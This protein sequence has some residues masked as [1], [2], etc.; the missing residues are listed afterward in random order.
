MATVTSEIQIV[1]NPT[2]TVPELG[3]VKGVQF[4]NG[5]SQYVGI[6]FAEIPGRFRLSRLLTT[7]LSKVEGEFDATKLGPYSHQPSRS[8]P[9]PAADRPWFEFPEASE[10]ECL[11]INISVPDTKANKDLLPVMVYIHGGAYAYG[12]GVS[13][14]YDGMTLSTL[15]AKKDQP[16][17]VITFN[18]RL[19]LPGF[20][21]SRDLL[22]YRQSLGEDGVGNYGIWDQV[23]ALRWVNRYIESFGGDI[24]RI[25]VFGQSAGSQ[26]VHLHTLRNEPL[27]S[28]AI[29][30]SGLS[31]LCGIFSIEEYDIVYEKVLKHLNIDTHQPSYDR[32][33]ALINVPIEDLTR[34]MDAVFNVSCVTL[35]LTDD[36][37]LLAGKSI[38]AASDFAQPEKTVL[39][40]FCPRLLIGNV[41]NESII[42]DDEWS[43]YSASGLINFIHEFIGNKTQ[44]Q[45]I[46][47]LYNIDKT[48]S[49]RQTYDVIEKIATDGLF[50][51]ISDQFITKTGPEIELYTYF[52]DQAC[53]FN[54]SPWK[55][56]AHHSYDNV[57]VWGTLSPELDEARLKLS[58]E[59]SI[60]WISFANGQAPWNEFHQNQQ[61]RIFDSDNNQEKY[62][63]REQDAARG[64]STWK[65]LQVEGLFE[66]VRRLGE[67]LC[68][69]RQNLLN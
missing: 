35:P 21:A 59:I 64:Y 44:S 7:P 14:M 11:N 48:L 41:R 40:D 2:V 5:T 16:T 31:P 24:N 9:I 30:Q 25:T 20:L 34:A 15:S 33:K 58:K 60:A 4:N 3:K 42:W 28:S 49:Q 29:M 37:V 65:A 10:L 61:Y 26:S 52:F 22:E 67:E 47:D 27:F 63:T 53:G 8:F 1:S 45:R 43:H 17:I 56:Y 39:S 54:N 66:T 38:P 18:Y 46:L 36:L 62:R 19:G 69:K 6:P 55:G 32:V 12:T 57:F 23:I 51:V 13:P 68:L 50:L